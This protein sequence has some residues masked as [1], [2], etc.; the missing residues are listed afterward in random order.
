MWNQRWKTILSDVNSDKCE[1]A[2]WILGRIVACVRVLVNSCISCTWRA[3]ARLSR[4]R[5]YLLRLFCWLNRKFAFNVHNYPHAWRHAKRACEMRPFI[6][7]L[8]Q[9]TIVEYHY[10]NCSMF[11]NSFSAI[12]IQSVCFCSCSQLGQ[13]VGKIKK[14]A[15][16]KFM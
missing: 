13:F 11:S 1:V 10:F 12:W 5:P 3:R 9:S 14:T 15:D 16:G 8:E 2:Q 4:H 6:L 7:F